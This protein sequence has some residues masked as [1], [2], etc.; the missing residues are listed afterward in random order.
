MAT[1]VGTLGLLL[2]LVVR[3]A[4]PPAIPVV[5]APPP[6]TVVVSSQVRDELDAA[7][8]MLSQV[9][10]AALRAR[11]LARL[12]AARSLLLRLERL[13]GGVGVVVPHRDG[14]VVVPGGTVPDRVPARASAGRFRTPLSDAEFDQLSV[15][16]NATSFSSQ[17]L[18]QLRTATQD[19]SVTVA[20]VVSLLGLFSFGRDQVEAAAALH[21]RVSDPAGWSR[22]YSVFKFTSDADRLR[23][24]VGDT[25]SVR[26]SRSR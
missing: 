11:V 5:Q 18:K 25:E 23:E 14:V 1:L 19:R 20:Q 7:E 15:D 6:E 4:S 24:R 8:A 26:A 12:D 13:P 2:P 3:A 17:Q 22:V 21:D 9:E 10:D 16:L